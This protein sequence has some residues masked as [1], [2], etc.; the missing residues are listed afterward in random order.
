MKIGILGTG[1]VA[2]A[3]GKGFITLGH[4]VKLGGRET[5]NEKGA[6]WAKEMG[7]KASTGTFADAAA[8]GELVVLSTLGSAYEAVLKAA[9]PERLG[10]KVLIDTTNP[11]DFSK[12][13]PP[14]LSVGHTDSGGEQ[15]QRAVPGARVVKAF[16][17]V[18]NASMFRPDF[19]GG[20]PDMLICGNDADAKK[21]VTTILHDFGWPQ[22]T[23]L[24]G[25]ESSKYLEALCITWVLFGVAKGSWNHALKFV[26]K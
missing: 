11:L 17:I 14:R 16:N 13:M 5:Q 4:E 1:D 15:V 2:R 7:A 21:Q 22:V 12:G 19:P 18:G 3:I 8:F 9:G 24:G 26:Q 20:P 10:G 23:D 6:A 25:I